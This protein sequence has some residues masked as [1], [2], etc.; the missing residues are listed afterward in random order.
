MITIS[1][2]VLITDVLNVSASFAI[3]HSLGLSLCF[4]HISKRFSGFR[5]WKGTSVGSI[6]DSGESSSTTAYPGCK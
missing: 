6:S 3:V 5:Y 1:A 4:S 2:L